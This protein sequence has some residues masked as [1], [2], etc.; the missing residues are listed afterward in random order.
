MSPRR[1]AALPTPM[2]DARSAIVPDD[3][4]FL[5]MK[6]LSA[7]IRLLDRAQDSTTLAARVKEGFEL[8]RADAELS[9]GQYYGAH[10]LTHCLT[11]LCDHA[12]RRLIVL[13]AQRHRL[14]EA[15]WCWLALGSQGRGELTYASDQDNALIFSAIDG[16]ESGILRQLLL[17]FAEAINEGLAHCGFPLCKGLIMAGNPAW[18]L[19]LEE[20][21]ECFSQWIRTPEPEALL[22]TTIF[23]DFRALQGDAA[24]ASALR[25]YLLSLTRGNAGFLRM[26]ANN[27]LAVAPPLGTL[28]TFSPANA[29]KALDLKTYGARLF[30]DAARIFA[31]GSGIQAVGTSA[32]LMAALPSR[33]DGEAA[34]GAF[35]HIQQLRLGRQLAGGSE[36]SAFIDPGQLNRYDQ[37][38]LKE[39]LEQARSIQ[40]SLSTRYCREI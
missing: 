11:T 14:P 18:C 40:G 7:Q 24:L 28:R 30:V 2:H 15:R 34:V 39:A 23:F 16:K 36:D 5:A 29:G 26:M 19:S 27:A 21:K 8:L 4:A 33:R 35:L 37:R 25:Q 20:W 32:R 12:T 17:P 38:L 13:C 1:P 31:L 3:D 22:N 10:F 9:S 6:R